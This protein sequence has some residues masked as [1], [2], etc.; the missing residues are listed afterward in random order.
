VAT[1]II[2]TVAG[3]YQRWLDRLPDFQEGSEQ[4]ERLTETIEELE[5]AIELLANLQLPKGFG[6]D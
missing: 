5:Q 1:K 2:S 3:E 4:Q 6:R